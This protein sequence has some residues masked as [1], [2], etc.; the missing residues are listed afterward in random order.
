MTLTICYI[1]SPGAISISSPH[2]PGFPALVS[3][4]AVSDYALEWRI[5]LRLGEPS[6]MQRIGHILTRRL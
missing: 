2:L 4:F 6:K 3:A 5:L 1:A